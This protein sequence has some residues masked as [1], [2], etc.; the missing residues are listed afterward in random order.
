MK[1]RRSAILRNAGKYPITG[2]VEFDSVGFGY[3]S[4]EPVLKD[5]N[6]KI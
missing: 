3:K 5:I 6:L 1:S 4:Y 2:E